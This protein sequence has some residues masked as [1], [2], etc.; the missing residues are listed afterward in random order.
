MSSSIR[1]P[2]DVP[3]SVQ[4]GMVL[5]EVE[6]MSTADRLRILVRAGLATEEEIE[7]T[8]ERLGPEAHQPR[9]VRA[10]SKRGGAES[11]GQIG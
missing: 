8:I 10:R 11:G 2:E 1:R 4:M 7:A 3:M 9:K 5:E 6:R